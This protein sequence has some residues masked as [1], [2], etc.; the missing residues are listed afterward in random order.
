MI[1]RLF[2]LFHDKW[3]YSLEDLNEIILFGVKNGDLLI[4]DMKNYDVYYDEVDWDIKN[5]Y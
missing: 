3:K 5:P 2:Y 1:D 4:A